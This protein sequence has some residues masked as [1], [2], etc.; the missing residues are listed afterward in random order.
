[1]KASKIKRQLVRVG[2]L[3]VARS[4]GRS[5][6]R[7]RCG[8]GCGCSIERR[9]TPVPA[10]ANPSRRSLR[11]R[12]P[13]AADGILDIPYVTLELLERVCFRVDCPH[14]AAVDR[15][16]PVGRRH[17]SHRS[18]YRLRG[19]SVYASR[20]AIAALIAAT[21]NIVAVAA[22]SSLMVSRMIR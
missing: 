18:G 13:N 15:S 4:V 20:S 10:I 19:A 1:V 6:D 3:V 8:C 5:G 17:V 7:R 2:F 11:R 12:P 21:A 22:T 16:Y 9:S 14:P